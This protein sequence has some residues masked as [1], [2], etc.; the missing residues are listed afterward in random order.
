MKILRHEAGA[1]D[2]QRLQAA[3]APPAPAAVRP[4][5]HAVSGVSAP[6]KP[7][8]K[9]FVLHL[10]SWYTQSHP[11]ED[12]AETFAVWLNPESDWRLRYA[13]WPAVKK[14]EYMDSFDGRGR[15]QAGW[16]C[17][18]AAASSHSTP[19]ARRCAA[20]YCG[21]GATT[22]SSIPNFYDRDLRKL[23]SDR[24]GAR[25]QH[26][27]RALHRPGCGLTY[28]GIGI[29]SWTGKYQYTINQVLENMIKRANELNLR[30]AGPE[31]R[32][33]LDFIVL[34]TV[35]TMNYLHGGHPPGRPFA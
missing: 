3:A 19:S 6:P 28:A 2:R 30:L 4:V 18:P 35:Q 17:T 11:D 14:L 20:H 27:G 23:F 16:W 1:R 31:E 33:K 29:A 10:D 24:T 7:Y 5:L 13:D 8:S 15:R 21:S 9:S 12:F 25:R 32:A 22:E 34:L 26:E